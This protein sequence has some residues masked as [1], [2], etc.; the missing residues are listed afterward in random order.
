[1][2]DA[3]FE[4][5][6][7]RRVKDEELQNLVEH[8]VDPKLRKAATEPRVIRDPVAGVEISVEFSEASRLYMDSSHPFQLNQTLLAQV[9]TQQDQSCI[10]AT[11]RAYATISGHGLAVAVERST[12]GGLRR[13]LSALVSLAEDRVRLLVSEL[14]R[15]LLEPGVQEQR[16]AF[17]VVSLSERDLPRIVAA[18]PT[19][20]S[21]KLSLRAAIRQKCNPA[22]T[23]AILPLLNASHFLAP[24]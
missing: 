15:A 19:L 11:L 13:V 24:R 16:L 20:S 8:L 9:L 14:D 17:L 18:F 5:E 1:M 7:R 21:I 10:A 4:D 12:A 2:Y 23:R 6:L 22:F 3:P